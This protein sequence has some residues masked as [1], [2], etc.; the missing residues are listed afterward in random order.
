M[1][2]IDVVVTIIDQMCVYKTDSLKYHTRVVIYIR[3]SHF[4]IKFFSYIVTS[5][6]FNSLEPAG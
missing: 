6:A 1:N 4:I 3:K 5:V 2:F